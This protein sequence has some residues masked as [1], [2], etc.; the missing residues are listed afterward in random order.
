MMFRGIIS[1]DLERKQSMKE[2]F[3]EIINRY[4]DSLGNVFSDPFKKSTVLQKEDMWEAHI[5]TTI[6][7]LVQ[8]EN[9]GYLFN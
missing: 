9:F 7:F 8:S 4:I 3:Y 5:L 6:D 1:D 2:Y